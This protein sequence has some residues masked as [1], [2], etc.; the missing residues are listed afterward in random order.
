LFF[1]IS[2]TI[3]VRLRDSARHVRALIE[4]NPSNFA[5]PKFECAHEF[6][7][8]PNGEPRTMFG[9]ARAARILSNRAHFNANRGNHLR[10]PSAEGRAQNSRNPERHEYFAPDNLN[11]RAK[12]SEAVSRH[13]NLSD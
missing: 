5:R 12:W 6:T 13:A 8:S 10:R 7:S 1:D 11:L 2:T 3:L 9:F 4:L